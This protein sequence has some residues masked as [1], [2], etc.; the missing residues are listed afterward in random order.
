MCKCMRYQRDQ[1]FTDFTFKPR[2]F[3]RQKSVREVRAM[4]IGGE[5]TELTDDW[6]TQQRLIRFL[7]F[8]NRLK[9]MT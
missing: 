4:V 2:T 8:E 1:C 6:S 5:Q 3:P 9:T 7:C